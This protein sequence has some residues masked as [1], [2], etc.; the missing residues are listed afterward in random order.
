MQT[1]IIGAGAVGGY[2]GA[3]LLEAGR[4]VTFLVRPGRRARLSASGLIV[5]SPYGDVALPAQTVLSHEIERPW[6]LII[7]SC[8][9]YDLADAMDGFAGAVGPNT[10]ILPLLNGMRHLDALSDQFGAD[11]VLGG[12]CSIGVTLDADGAILH[13]NRLH[14]I[15][16]GERGGG[17]SERT[18]AIANLFASTKTDWSVSAD[19]IQAMWEKWV[20]LSTLAASTCLLRANTGDIVS[21]GGADMIGA[22]LNEAQSVAV[23]AGRGAAPEALADMRELLTD[24]AS[25]F[26]AS[27]L[28]DMERGGPVEAD[29]VIGDLLAR[30]RAAGLTTPL[31][32][33]AYLHLKSYE[34][35]RRR[36]AAAE[37]G[38][39]V[40]GNTEV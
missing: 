8:K 32:E 30:A 10:A 11:R 40:Q 28:R 21:V 6:D 15:T 1:L 7:V 18:R 2:Y 4:D 27:M 39:A 29:H 23:S 25:S 26:T 35:R 16:F 9:A 20:I 33:L 38:A 31:L 14:S 36:E 17:E 22:L 12:T 34:A 13:F 19:V 3:R 37:T 5:K 24:P